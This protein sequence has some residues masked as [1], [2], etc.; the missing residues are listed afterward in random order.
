MFE[1]RAAWL[2][3]EYI[4]PTYFANLRAKYEPKFGEFYTRQAKQIESA[5]QEHAR[6]RQASIAEVELLTLCHSQLCA[7]IKVAQKARKVL[8]PFH[9]QIFKDPGAACLKLLLEALAST[10]KYE[11]LLRSTLEE[12]R[13]YL[14]I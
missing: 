2:C 4:M 1:A 12:Y 13:A 7:L 9:N 5:T 6:C 10:E 8:R 11:G 3:K 14:G